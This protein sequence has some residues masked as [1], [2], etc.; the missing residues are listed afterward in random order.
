MSNLSVRWQIWE[1]TWGEE[2]GHMSKSIFRESCCER[3]H[4]NG[5]LWC[6]AGGTTKRGTFILYTYLLSY[7]HSKDK[8]HYRMFGCFIQESLHST[9]LPQS[10]LITLNV[11][12]MN[13]EMDSICDFLKSY[14]A[15]S[16]HQ[17]SPRWWDHAVGFFISSPHS[18]ITQTRRNLGSGKN[19]H[20][21]LI[22]LLRWISV[23][24]PR[25]WLQ[26]PLS[27]ATSVL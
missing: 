11:K 5:M 9:S 21:I 7:L 23:F 24:E 27:Y 6:R 2:V 12:W 13:L 20:C 16:W 8:G 26:L 18:P 10:P 4:R 19:L 1:R 15:V 17:S 25:L 14:H 22:I 3:D